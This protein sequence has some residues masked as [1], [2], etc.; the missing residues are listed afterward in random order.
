MQ[1]LALLLVLKT[2]PVV[3]LTLLK[4][5][6]L[7]PL[8]VHLPQQVLLLTLPK[9]LLQLPWALQPTLLKVLWL[10]ALTL[11]TLPRLALLLPVPLLLTLLKLLWKPLARSNSSLNKKAPSGA[12][13]TSVLFCIG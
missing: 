12:F 9:V 6:L 7:V 8:R 10:P 4:M 13:F 11:V 3:L 5:Q 2:P 1:P